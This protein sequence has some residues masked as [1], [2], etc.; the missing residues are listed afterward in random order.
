MTEAFLDAA[1]SGASVSAAAFFGLGGL[2]DPSR[3]QRCRPVEEGKIR[4]ARSQHDRLSGSC[5]NGRI[6]T[7]RLVLAIVA[8]PGRQKISRRRLERGRSYVLVA[9][10]LESF[11]LVSFS[12]DGCFRSDLPWSYRTRSPSDAARVKRRWI[13]RFRTWLVRW[14]RVLFIGLAFLDLARLEGNV[15]YRVL[16]RTDLRV[17]VGECSDAG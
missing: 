5:R 10:V 13:A 17:V 6:R 12:V 8:A 7:G 14:I 16:S 4:K 2:S 9:S 15:G 1:V 3:Q 11:V